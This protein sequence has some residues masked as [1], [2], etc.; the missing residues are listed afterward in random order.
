MEVGE[1]MLGPYTAISHTWGSRAVEGD[2]TAGVAYRESPGYTQKLEEIRAAVELLG[3]KYFWIDIAC[4]DQDNLS[5]KSEEVKKMG[6]YY[7]NASRCLVHLDDLVASPMLLKS[8]PIFKE[9][10]N[11]VPS[12][13]DSATHI[14]FGMS[15]DRIYMAATF[16]INF[17]VDS[18]WG[19]RIW[20]IQE[21]SLNPVLDFIIPG[22]PE[23]LSSRM[24]ENAL[25][26]KVVSST[27][28]GARIPLTS[29]HF[30]PGFHTSI[31]LPL[32]NQIVNDGKS[33]IAQV[34]LAR[35]RGVTNLGTLLD[36][37]STR[38]CTLKEDRVYGLLGLLPYGEMVNVD[39]SGGLKN[40]TRELFE[41]AIKHGDTSGLYF[42]GKSHG[43]IP[44][45]ES[46]RPSF[47]PSF[48]LPLERV[49]SSTQMI[50]EHVGRVQD[51]IMLRENISSSSE[52][53]KLRLTLK[54]LYSVM[55][56][57]REGVLNNQQAM[58]A[59]CLS[60]PGDKFKV[61]VLAGQQGADSLEEQ[62][63]VRGMSILYGESRL[64]LAKVVCEG[65][66][67]K[68]VGV[69]S[70]EDISGSHLVCMGVASW[71][72]R[73]G[74]VVKPVGASTVH[75]IGGS[76]AV[77]KDEYSIVFIQVMDE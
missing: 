75:R 56:L 42:T 35:R 2:T 12:G 69:S 15:D 30:P 44:D 68:W 58:Y 38:G 34:I 5:E 3:D 71:E 33:N 70:D 53:D 47:I 61:H 4:I 43:M 31:S 62:Q 6:H 37:A 27:L 59:I 74:M 32:G 73:I 49:G 20:T 13:F 11:Q 60:M 65:K 18:L 41:V 77:P 45:L 25:F 19:T 52:D 40:A 16:M 23:V 55:D 22:M 28:A 46:S 54:A 24:I 57:T 67:D 26:L 14:M 51:V 36:L 8:Y 39:Y 72:D 29:D 7:R 1:R 66:D 63:A 50:V 9:Y 48:T 76:G 21:A 17:V 10:I 64:L